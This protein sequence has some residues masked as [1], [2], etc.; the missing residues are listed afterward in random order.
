MFLKFF[1]N[2]EKVRRLVE[3]K[4]IDGIPCIVLSDRKEEHEKWN[5]IKPENFSI[6]RDYTHIQ[7]SKEFDC[8]N[9]LMDDL[10]EKF[11]DK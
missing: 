6:L 4:V 5:K 3:I 2:Q 9:D 8:I 11:K 10:K 7:R 1:N